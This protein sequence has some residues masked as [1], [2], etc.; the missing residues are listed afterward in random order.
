VQ[1]VEDLAGLGDGAER[2]KAFC[3][4]TP[5]QKA[6]LNSIWPWAAR[7][8]IQGRSRSLEGSAEQRE[9][10]PIGDREGGARAGAAC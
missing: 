7:L 9:R 3:R 8:G 6:V 10:R 2:F 5:R 1:E 4:A